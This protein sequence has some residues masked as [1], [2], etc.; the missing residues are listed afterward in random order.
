MA[1]QHHILRQRITLE[2]GPLE[3]GEARAWQAK[4]ERFQAEHLRQVLERQFDRY[5]GEG[6]RVI[7]RIE[8]TLELDSGT[9][10][11]EEGLAVELEAL[12]GRELA[13]QLAHHSTEE[14]DLSRLAALRNL[15][16]TGNLHWPFEDATALRGWLMTHDWVKL[17]GCPKQLLPEVLRNTDRVLALAVTHH[18]W[19]DN[20]L[21]PL[22]PILEKFVVAAGG[23]D[24]LTP[25]TGSP[26]EIDEWREA[27][28]WAA[29]I[30]DGHWAVQSAKR[31]LAPEDSI[32]PRPGAS[33]TVETETA[34]FVENAGLILLH[35]YL[36]YLAQQLEYDFP[37]DLGRM[38][39]ILH[40]AIWGDVE[41]AE[42]DLPLIKVL[43]G[44]HPDELLTP[45]AEISEEAQ[46]TTDGVLAGVVEH[47]G[48]LGS[49][50]IDGLRE[51]FLQR[52]GKLSAV[53][54]GWQLNVEISAIDVL[55]DSLPWAISLVKTPW[56][57]GRMQ[58]VW[59]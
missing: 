11:L 10:S 36:N 16:R 42:W 3:R 58:I 38:A 27:L 17:P 55:M 56:M 7:D 32:V 46:N 23:W 40:Y 21:R 1:A 49:T 25:R 57:E 18:W 59:R 53:A 24:K 8:V 12:L 2:A 29:G 20:F 30:H 54:G 52:P 6:N 41:V 28:K 47:W 34:Y 19:R 35:P 26:K 51:G 37:R 44:L 14:S 48:R 5:G 45:A 13:K 15:I 4:L 39:A 31:E 9:P 33:G 43:L 50:S 22:W